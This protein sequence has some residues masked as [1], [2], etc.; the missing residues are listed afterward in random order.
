M[1]SNTFNE[2]IMFDSYN[3]G[4]Q[5]SLTFQKM[6]LGATETLLS[7]LALCCL[8]SSVTGEYLRLCVCIT[9]AEN[10]T[11]LSGLLGRLSEALHLRCLLSPALGTTHLS[12][13]NS[14][15]WVSE[16]RHPS[17]D[18]VCYWTGNLVPV[19]VTGIL[20]LDPMLIVPSHISIS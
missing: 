2:C 18:T 7:V 11:Y 4:K 17:H 14:T 13:F 3:L 1:P 20:T 12:P 19:L 10:S 6:G 15:C 8:T 5:S 16:M 9:Y